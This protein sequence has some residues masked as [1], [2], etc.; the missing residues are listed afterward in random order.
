MVV[1][2]RTMFA[3]GD[4]EIISELHGRFTDAGHNALRPQMEVLEKTAAIYEEDQRALQQRLEAQGQ[5]LQRQLSDKRRLEARLQGMVTETSMKWEK[6]CV[7]APAGLLS[8]A[9]GGGGVA[10]GRSAPEHCARSGEGSRGGAPS[11][12]RSVPLTSFLCLTSHD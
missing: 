11:S 7:S 8:G 1:L 10:S 9:A 4:C 3:Y 6:E 12:P 2:S 5:R